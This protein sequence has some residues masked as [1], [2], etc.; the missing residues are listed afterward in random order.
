VQ[1][2]DIRRSREKTFET[3]RSKR[4]GS[5]KTDNYHQRWTNLVWIF[6]SLNS[7]F[8]V[9][10][11]CDSSWI[12]SFSSQVNKILLYRSGQFRIV[13]WNFFAE[14]LK[15]VSIR[16]LDRPVSINETEMAFVELNQT[17]SSA[18]VLAC[19]KSEFQPPSKARSERGAG[20][21]YERQLLKSKVVIH[22]RSNMLW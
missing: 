14:A 2:K 18:H 4:S 7:N 6:T 11:R 10:F 3:G 19:K 12:H 5:I 8:H 1:I 20:K 21:R 22:E 16:F 9:N 13:W 17:R 15:D